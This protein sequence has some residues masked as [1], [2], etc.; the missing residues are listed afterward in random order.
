MQAGASFLETPVFKPCVVIPVYD[1]ECAIGQ[2]VARVLEH[3]L[4]CL[5]VD[6]GSGPICARTLQEI[7]RQSPEKISL[8]RHE[9]NRGKGAAVMTGMRFAATRGYSHVLQI[10]ADGQHDTA[11]IPRFIGAAQRQPQ[12]I[13][14]GCPIYDGSVPAIRFYGRYL[15]HVWV[16][17]N[18]L[19]FQIRDSMC[20]FRV[21]PVEA[22]LALLR[23]ERFGERMNFDTEVLVRL[24]WQGRKII[25]LPTKV[26]YPT[27]GVSHFRVW[28]DN[29]LISR[30]HAMLF[31]GMLLRAPKLLMRKW[32]RA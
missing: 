27:D 24:C 22:V 18:T 28:R 17:I 4:D 14:N 19:S 1:H 3:G 13:I 9:V 15:T 5:L 20:G 26:G 10:D 30:M 12:A 6:D 21:Y 11:D 31:V 2:V 29:V 32:S 8:L 16:W 25:N 23:S 7:A